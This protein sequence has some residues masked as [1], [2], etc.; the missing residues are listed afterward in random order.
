MATWHLPD[1]NCRPGRLDSSPRSRALLC[2]SRRE[3]RLWVF[4]VHH[5]DVG[6][7]S[8]LDRKHVYFVVDHG[9][10]SSCH[11]QPPCPARHFIVQQGERPRRIG[12]LVEG[13][14]AS[15]VRLDH[16]PH[17]FHHLALYLGRHNS[18]AYAF[19]EI[20]DQHPGTGHLRPA[21]HAVLRQATSMLQEDTT[22]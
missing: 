11:S 12:S 7:A 21:C 6:S 15:V 19:D 17:V 4:H 5:I 10:S 13:Q 22:K 16:S 8:R 18:M 2:H 20:V 14:A 1:G 9:I 3:T